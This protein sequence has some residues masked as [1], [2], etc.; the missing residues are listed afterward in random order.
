[1]SMILVLQTSGTSWIKSSKRKPSASA[2]TCGMGRNRSADP[3]DPKEAPLGPRAGV[4][5]EDSHGQLQ[6]NGSMINGQGHL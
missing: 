5:E 3:K 1:M 2:D 4:S 6:P